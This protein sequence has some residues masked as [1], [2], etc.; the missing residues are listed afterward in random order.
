[1]VWNQNK[2]KETMYKIFQEKL[3]IS[4]CNLIIENIS[5]K[6]LSTEKRHFNKSGKFFF[7]E[8][9]NRLRLLKNILVELLKKTNV[10]KKYNNIY[11]DHA[12]LLLKSKGGNPTKPHQDIAFWKKIE[13]NKVSMITFWIALEDIDRNKGC[14]LVSSKQEENLINFNEK[15]RYFKHTKIKNTLLIKQDLKKIIFK[16]LEVLKGN[17]VAFDAF[18]LHGSTNNMKTSPRLA[19]K[20]VF[21]EGKGL[22]SVNN[23]INYFYLT[24]LIFYAKKVLK[25]LK[26]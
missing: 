23:F 20:I 7:Y 14:L 19:F 12:M 15:K 4:L 25:I 17:I 21:R 22:F 16:P 13:K 8:N 2:I 3:S 1:V 5:G 26:I 18:E 9:L 11:L 24:A 6:F 10:T